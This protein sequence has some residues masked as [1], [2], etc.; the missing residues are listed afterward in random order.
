[1]RSDEIFEP[2]VL[3]DHHRVRIKGDTGVMS[4]WTFG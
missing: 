2:N 3:K 4:A 1:M